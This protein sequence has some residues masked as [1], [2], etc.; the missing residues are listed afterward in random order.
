MLVP[1]AHGTGLFQRGETQVLNIA[2]L[3]MPA[4][5]PDDRR[6]RSRRGLASA[7]STTTTSRRS[8]P[9]ETGFMRGP[10]RREIGHG[11]RS[12]SALCCRWS[13]RLRGL[14]RTRCGWSLRSSV[15]QRFDV[16]GL[17]LFVVAVADGRRRPD[18]GSGGGHRHGS[19]LRRR[20]V[21]DPHRHPRRRG[22][23]RRH[24]LQG[25]R[26]GRLRDGHSSSTPRSTGFPSD[27]SWPAAL[28]PGPGCPDGRSSTSWP[29]AIAERR[30]TT[31][32]RHRPQDRQLRDSDRQDRRRDRS[33]RARSS[34]PSRPRPVRRSASTTTAPW[35][36]SASGPP[37]AAPCPRP[38]VRSR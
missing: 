25:G 11:L 3:G 20:Q 27:V 29:G 36:R 24:G 31:C 30:A 9:G 22:C 21:H 13:R 8:R 2:T 19:G 37:M 6:H 28:E 33:R 10:K 35:A 26:N 1:M 32:R 38:S 4:H 15:L 18:Q 14:A 7:T 5:G 34:T 12:P 16:D 17:G 23:L